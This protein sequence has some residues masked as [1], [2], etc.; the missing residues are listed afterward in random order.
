MAE[1]EQNTGNV[2]ITNKQIYEG[3]NNITTSLA[4]HSQKLDLHIQNDKS[5]LDDHED[6]IRKIEET[7]WRSSWITSFITAIITAVAVG[8][9][10]NFFGA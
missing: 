10:V 4:L 3:L 5:K 2:R 8:L 7:M 6:R 9:T 1:K